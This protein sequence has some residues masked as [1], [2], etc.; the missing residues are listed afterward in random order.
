L[1]SRDIARARPKKDA[2]LPPLSQKSISDIAQVNPILVN[3][4][5]SIN[6]QDERVPNTGTPAKELGTQEHTWIGRTTSKLRSTKS[7]FGVLNGVQSTDDLLLQDNSLSG[8]T[9]PDPDIS[10]F[11]HRPNELSEELVRTVALLHQRAAES[12][13]ATGLSR[14]S[15]G[16][17][18]SRRR[19]GRR[20]SHE[21]S[22]TDTVAEQSIMDPYNVKEIYPS[23]DIGVYA[24][25][26]EVNVLPIESAI[27][28]CT[29][30]Y[31]RLQGLLELLKHV[32]PKELNHKQ[33]LPF[34][35]NIYNTI[36]LHATLMYGVPKNHYKRV[37]LMNKVTYIVGGHQYSPL[38][39][40]HAILRSN[41]YRPALASL[42]PI[43]KLKKTDEVAGSSLDNP[44]PLVSF[45]L[46]C[47]SRSSPVLRVYT[48][49]NV[50]TEL[51]QA[52]R[53]YLM[54]AV[55][56]NKKKSIMIPKILHWYAR[57]FSHDA[58]SLIQWIAA[59]LPASK[60][61]AFDECTKQGRRKSS[62]KT[63]IRHRMSVQPYD[64]SFRYL[65]DPMLS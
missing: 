46:C 42:L 43:P 51:E 18:S 26:L 31:R 21:F 13:S 7:G 9:A 60:Q 49:T 33:R 11:S 35:I 59:K 40:E 47:G 3:G 16:I 53:D 55:G 14:T 44:E 64:W 6:R 2:G 61:A 12:H 56:V 36:M 65:Y 34:W 32:E 20:S 45:A 10:G 19:L 29:A 58:E 1:D 4:H 48:A 38:M 63:T 57:D 17:S 41:S 24:D 37:N 22:V 28:A 27:K 30:L 54:A 15:S 8:V 5:E 50:E 52:C 23:W 39:I 25:S 62:A